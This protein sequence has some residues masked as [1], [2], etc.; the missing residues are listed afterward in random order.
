[1]GDGAAVAPIGQPLVEIRI[2]IGAQ[3]RQRDGG[4]V[5]QLVE[6]VGEL[7]VLGRAA[8]ADDLPKC[9]R[10]R[11]LDGN[12]PA[13]VVMANAYITGITCP[14]PPLNGAWACRHG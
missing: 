3:L 13:V 5:A 9:R 6:Q 4:R 8:A 7:S 11:R 1:V 2:S 10:L 14:W 12:S